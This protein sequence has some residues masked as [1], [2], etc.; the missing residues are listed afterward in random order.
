MPTDIQ[1]TSSCSAPPLHLMA[2]NTAC[3]R[4][5]AAADEAIA[6]GAA[7]LVYVRVVEGG[8]IEAA[9]PVMEGLTSDQQAALVA[10]LGGQPGDLL[11]LAAGPPATVNKAL[12][13]VRLYL[14]NSLG[15]IKVSACLWALV[16]LADCKGGGTLLVSC[17]AVGAGLRSLG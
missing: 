13:R 8:G 2:A 1:P 6:G 4:A 16:E 17:F 3:W 15:L 11:L 9:K 12:D 10:G 7:G 5:T 14:G